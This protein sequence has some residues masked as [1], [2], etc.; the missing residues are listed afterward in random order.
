MNQFSVLL[1]RQTL[2]PSFPGTN[3]I[4]RRIEQRLSLTKIDETDNDFWG[5][6]GLTLLHEPLEPL[7]DFIFVHGLGGGSRKTWSKTPN[8]THY[9][10]KEWLPIE[11]R[12]KNVRIHTFGYNANWRER[13]ASTLTIHDFGQALLMDIRNSPALVQDGRTPQ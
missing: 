6:F 1:P 13:D 2:R 12:F 11:P 9:W 10:I 3:F 4:S 5:L 7:I 8:I